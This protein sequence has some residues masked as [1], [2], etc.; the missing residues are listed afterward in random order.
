MLCIGTMPKVD[1]PTLCYALLIVGNNE[2]TYSSQIYILYLEQKKMQIRIVTQHCE[3]ILVSLRC[4]WLA[5]DTLQ[6][7]ARSGIVI[8]VNGSNPCPLGLICY[9]QVH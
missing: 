9:F 8:L 5:K 4:S 3:A 7:L 2:L 6:P 1:R